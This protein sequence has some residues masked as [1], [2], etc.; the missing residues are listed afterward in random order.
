MASW[1]SVCV[2]LVVVNIF[3]LKKGVIFLLLCFV[4]RPIKLLFLYVIYVLCYWN[5]LQYL[6]ERFFL[7]PTPYDHKAVMRKTA[8]YENHKL[9]LIHQTTKPLSKLNTKPIYRLKRDVNFYYEKSKGM[10]SRVHLSMC[11]TSLWSHYG[12]EVHIY[13]CR[14][15]VT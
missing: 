11:I 1:Q 5:K 12:A 15:P 6:C 7:F 4:W 9:T 3:P 8:P 10:N 13:V 2:L 14:V